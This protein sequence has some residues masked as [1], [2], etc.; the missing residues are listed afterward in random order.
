MKTR[1]AV[2]TATV[3]TALLTSLVFA[4]FYLN[5]PIGITGNISAVNNFQVYSDPSCT[6][7]LTSISLGE[8]HRNDVIEKDFYIKD[9]GEGD[10]NTAYNLTGLPSDI[11]YTMRFGEIEGTHNLWTPDTP[12]LLHVGTV[13]IMM[14]ELTVSGSATFQPVSFTVNIYATA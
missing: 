12:V 8:V 7:V 1:T 13:W 4:A 9:I 3:V 14:L 2:I 6:T 11:T 5:R 10:V